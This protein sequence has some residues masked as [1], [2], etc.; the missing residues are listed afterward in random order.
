MLKQYFVSL[1]LVAALLLGGVPRTLAGTPTDRIVFDRPGERFT[2]SA[3]VGNGRLGAMDFGGVREARI[4]LNE[5]TLWSG[6]PLDQNREGAWKN[7]Q[8]IIDLLL[9]G[10]NVEAEALVNSTFTSDGPGSS[11]GSGRDGPFGCYQVMGTLT[12]KSAGMDG[13]VSEYERWLDLSH[14]EAVTRFR[15]AGAAYQREVIASHPDRII[16]LRLTTDAAAGLDVEVS[17]TRPERAA[18]GVEDGDLVM[19]GTL[20]D[21]A[22]GAGMS[23]VT[24][25]RVVTT[26]RVEAGENTLQIKGAKEAVVLYA[27]GT[28]YAGPIRGDHYGAAYEARVRADIE[29][30]AAKPWSELVERHRRDYMTIEG[31]VSLDLGPAAEG[32]TQARLQAVESGASDPALAALLFKFG[33][34]LMISSSREGGLPANLQG[35]WAEETQTPWNGDYHADINV[36]M[37]YWGV[38]VTAL[39]E[40][41]PPLTE[42]IENLREPG[43]RTA[44]AYYNAPGWV[45]HVI[46]NVWGFTAPGE[47]ASWG[48]TMSGAAWLCDH[49][50]EHYAFTGDREYLRRVY[51]IMRESCEF[52][53]SVLIELPGK[54]WLVTGPSNSPENGFRMKDGRDA[55][56]CLGPSMDQQLLR[57]LFDNTVRA[58]DVLG[59]DD[60]W[61][62]ELAATR[63]RLA[64]NQIGPDGCLQEWLEPYEEPEPTHRHVSHLYALYPGNE[65]TRHGTPELAAA[66]RKTLE[67]R[68]DRS[69]GWSMAWKACFWARLGDGDRAESLVRQALRPVAD[70][71]FNYRNQGGSYPNLFGAHP[72]FQID[73]NFGLAAAIAE[74][75]VQSHEETRGEGPTINL[76][77]ALPKSW[78]DGSVKGLRARGGYQVDIE[79]RNGA[80]TEAFIERLATGHAGSASVK[81]RLPGV[82]ERRV[83][84]VR[85]GDRYRV[86]P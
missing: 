29:R 12:L 31:R 66:A 10:K 4:V 25:I 75:L 60:A 69:T 3:P 67:V 65:I 13:P 19:R 34:Y 74:M 35:L 41:Q 15:V 18:I 54:G 80:I 73:S 49:L 2:E 46:T 14:A 57:E 53:R 11:H 70:M 30:A 37:N 78:P 32:S 64:P 71:G 50:W 68:G 8:P 55:H 26:G 24:R 36:Q 76:L 39:P 86:V 79:W 61:R 17:L 84:Q 27:A 21:G 16:A 56:T 44:R 51:P 40:C 52:Y 22:G 62:V 47:H 33:R 38:D 58:A 77:P 72:P 7:R 82:A 85:V 9:Q 23:Y 83:I 43:A 45:S 5:N 20:N 42:L 6:R 28:S 48:S 81:V 1:I 63:E 59:I